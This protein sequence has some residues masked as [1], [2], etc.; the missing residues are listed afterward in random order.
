MNGL[1]IGF[2]MVARSS[3]KETVFVANRVAEILDSS[4][5]DQWRPVDGTLNLADIGTRGKSVL[6]L[7]KGEWYT[8]P[9]WLREK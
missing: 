4:T 3:Q 7:E 1:D 2:A 6:E 5:I 8:W 9:T